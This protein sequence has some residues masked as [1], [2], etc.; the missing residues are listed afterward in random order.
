MI[1]IKGKNVQN[2][3]KSARR[4]E[5]P[6]IENILCLLMDSGESAIFSKSFQLMRR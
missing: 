1:H 4:R 5:I 6:L 3:D 2:P